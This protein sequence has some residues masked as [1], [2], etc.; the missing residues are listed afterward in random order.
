MFTVRQIW[1]G[2]AV[3]LLVMVLVVVSTAF[4][5]HITGVH[6]LLP[7]LGEFTPQGC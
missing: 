5:S 2:L 7:L 1:I 3:L 4:W 6:N